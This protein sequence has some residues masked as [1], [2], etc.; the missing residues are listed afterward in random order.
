MAWG[1][2]DSP[3]AGCVALPAVGA[4]SSAG[5]L[6]A[7]RRPDSSSGGPGAVLAARRAKEQ[8]RRSQVGHCH[9]PKIGWLPRPP[10][11]PFPSM[12]PRA[13]VPISAGLLVMRGHSLRL[14][15]FLPPVP[16]AL[17]THCQSFW[18]SHRNG[19]AGPAISLG[20]GS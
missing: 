11:T 14:M 17:S 12:P 4:G 1:A 7:H 10:L 20:F 18:F 8:C 2:Q 15:W 19:G 13:H 5:T 3:A 9:H 6:C 16:S